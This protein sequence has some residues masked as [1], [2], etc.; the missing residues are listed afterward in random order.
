MM[1][2]LIVMM[3]NLLH[4]SH[5]HYQRL[6]KNHQWKSPRFDTESEAEDDA[7]GTRCVWAILFRFDSVI[8]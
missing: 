4:Q 3:Q 8:V 1:K 7:V 5:P 2:I 6:K